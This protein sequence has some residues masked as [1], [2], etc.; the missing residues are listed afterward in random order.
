MGV[1]YKAQD[2]KLN[3]FVALKFLLKKFRMMCSLR[4]ASNADP[5]VTVVNRAIRLTTKG[6]D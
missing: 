5:E 2:L 1:V 3:R 6:D 4:F